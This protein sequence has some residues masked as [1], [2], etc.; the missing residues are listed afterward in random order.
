ME[1]NAFLICGDF[2]FLPPDL[3]LTNDIPKPLIKLRFTRNT[4]FPHLPNG[5]SKQKFSGLSVC[6]PSSAHKLMFQFI[7]MTIDKSKTG[8]LAGY[9][10]FIVLFLDS[11]MY[12]KLTRE[13]SFN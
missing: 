13:S 1:K 12:G 7:F 4:I 3:Y 8:T 9:N 2:H 10:V 11:V 6:N 5:L